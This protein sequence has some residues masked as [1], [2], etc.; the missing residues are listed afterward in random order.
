[1]EKRLAE[2]AAAQAVGTAEAA[3]KR[4]RQIVELLDALEAQ[5]EALARTIASVRDLAAGKAPEA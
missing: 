1:L 5:Q 2:T 4:L 3:E